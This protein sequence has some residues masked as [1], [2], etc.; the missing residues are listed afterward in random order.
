MNRK[1][2]NIEI[3]GVIA[4]AIL[5]KYRS[6][7]DELHKNILYKRELY[8]SSP[9]DFEDKKDCNLEEKIPPKEQLFEEYLKH[10]PEELQN[11]SDEE[12]E[13][14]ARYMEKHGLYAHPEAV[15]RMANQIN[16]E[17]NK[18]R[19]VLSLSKRWN[20]EYMWENYGDRHRGFCVGFNTKALIETN[21]FGGGGEV[22]YNKELPQLSSDRPVD[23]N[24]FDNLMAKK[25]E[26]VNEEEYRLL[27]TWNHIPTIAERTITIPPDCF[28]C[29]I[30]GKDMS[31]SDKAEMRSIQMAYLPKVKLY[32][33]IDE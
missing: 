17:T 29:I 27:K 24:I 3:N 20:N 7:H 18:Q 26:Y 10:L 2:E 33:L 12:K 23:Q 15:Q 9:N 5:Y 14:Y 16:G 32:E 21:L 30:M 8:L 22:S 19:G 13:R 31:E 6:F 4:P 28:E 1:I 11:A 25:D